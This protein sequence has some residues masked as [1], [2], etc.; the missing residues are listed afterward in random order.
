MP[1]PSK[2][3]IIMIKIGM[4]LFLSNAFHP[5]NQINWHFVAPIYFQITFT[6]IEKKKALNRIHKN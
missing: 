1:G 4:T 5:N 6:L 3:K 2:Q